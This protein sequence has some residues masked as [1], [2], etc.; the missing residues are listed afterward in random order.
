[1]LIQNGFSE[2]VLAC[3]VCWGV[4]FPR[5][6]SR[7]TA[8][9][10]NTL[11]HVF[12]LLPARWKGRDAGTREPAPTQA[13]VDGMRAEGSPGTLWPG[14]GGWPLARPM[15]TPMYALRMWVSGKVEG[16]GQRLR[17]DLQTKLE[18]VFASHSPPIYRVEK[19]AV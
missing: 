10:R 11:P 19:N 15:N 18:R 14:S 13:C 2:E 3:D 5:V 6:T 4:M 1:M 12:F 16:Y 9:F 7:V 8:F 17:M